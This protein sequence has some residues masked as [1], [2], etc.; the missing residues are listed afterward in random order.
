MI[1]IYKPDLIIFAK[2]KMIY[3]VSKMTLENNTTSFHLLDEKN[4]HVQYTSVHQ[5]NSSLHRGF[6]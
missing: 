2:R 6:L 1:V 5:I 3:T 4:K